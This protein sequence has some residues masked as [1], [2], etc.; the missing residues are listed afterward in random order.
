MMTSWKNPRIPP[1]NSIKSRSELLNRP[2]Q[3]KT[4][5]SEV[6]LAVFRVHFD[7][8]YDMSNESGLRWWINENIWD[9]IAPTFICGNPSQAC[10][11]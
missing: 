3:L 7:A 4:M 6:F 9:F 1:H 8:H 11:V 2:E 5:T 10:T